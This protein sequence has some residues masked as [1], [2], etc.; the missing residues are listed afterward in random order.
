MSTHQL[1]RQLR[2]QSDVSCIYCEIRKLVTHQD[3][4]QVL[5]SCVEVNKNV[6]GWYN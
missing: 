3:D 2:D 4:K 1:T 6:K 5:I